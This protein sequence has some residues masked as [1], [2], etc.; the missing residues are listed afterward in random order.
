MTHI[1]LTSVPLLF[2][3]VREL[4]YQTLL[5]RLFT[6]IKLVLAASAGLSNDDH[7]PLKFAEERKTIACPPY[8]GKHSRPLISSNESLSSKQRAAS[9]QFKTDDQYRSQPL[10]VESEI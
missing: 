3:I 4:D 10:I 2:I 1:R 6:A 8:D 7:L 9:E 5:L